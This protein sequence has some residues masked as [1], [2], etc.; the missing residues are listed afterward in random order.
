M[1]LRWRIWNRE[2][3]VYQHEAVN[4]VAISKAE[5]PQRLI[6]GRLFA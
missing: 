4:N 5:L 1:G 2:G 3:G 6:T